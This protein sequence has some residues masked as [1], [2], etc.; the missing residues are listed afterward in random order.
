M[1][2]TIGSYTSRGG[3]GFQRGRQR[4]PTLQTTKSVTYS[5]T[6]SDQIF[7][8]SSDTSATASNPIPSAI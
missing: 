3:E 8:I 7:S 2:L 4:T 1:P 6:Q 5:A